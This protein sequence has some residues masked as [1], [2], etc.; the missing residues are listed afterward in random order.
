MCIDILRA[1]MSMYLMCMVLW[2][3]EEGIRYHRT[4]VRT[5]CEVACE[6]W[7]LNQSSLEK[8]PMLLAAEPS[9]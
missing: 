7:D 9:P 6:C 4:G 1:Y 8:Q 2:R 5:N 3:P